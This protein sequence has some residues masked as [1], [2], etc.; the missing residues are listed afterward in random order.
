MCF[1][2]MQHLYA[3]WSCNIRL[4]EHVQ[5][6]HVGIYQ[7]GHPNLRLPCHDTNVSA[8]FSKQKKLFIRTNWFWWRCGCWSYILL[9]VNDPWT[10]S[11][12]RK[13]AKLCRGKFHSLSKKFSVCRHTVSSFAWKLTIF[14]K[15]IRCLSM[16]SF[17]KKSK[18]IRTLKN[19][20]E[21][22][23]NTLLGRPGLANECEAFSTH[24]G[25]F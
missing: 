16:K 15:N 12:N 4:R 18:T 9:H 23:T 1:S 2:D 8:R 3:W 21:K 14:N 24:V 25:N 7:L 19:L 5:F 13:W 10:I 6:D 17:V 11:N 22:S 20:H